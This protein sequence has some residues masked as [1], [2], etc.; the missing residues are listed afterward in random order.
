MTTSKGFTLIELLLGLT[1]F[2]V[3]SLCLYSTFWSGIKLSQRSEKNNKVYREIGWTLEQMSRDL[4]NTVSYDFTNSYPDKLAFMGEAKRITFLK[5]SDEGLKAV[6]YYLDEPTRAQIQKTVIGK[7]YQKN[8]N[9]V[10]RSEESQNVRNLVREEQPFI[11]YVSGATDEGQKEILSTGVK[12]DGLKFLYGF[13][14][15]E[16]ST[17]VEW[18]SSWGENFIPAGLHVAISFVNGDPSR[19]ALDI[20]RDILIP[21]GSW[22]QPKS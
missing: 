10:L 14:V 15:K 16:D 8:V 5:T 20:Q 3:I 4:E 11:D 9:Q 7:T 1:I 17:E 21:T 12:A 22:G 18:K 19:P 13:F 2:S 6:S